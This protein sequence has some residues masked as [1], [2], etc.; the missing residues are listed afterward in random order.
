M[1]SV[2]FPTSVPAEQRFNLSDEDYRF[3]RQYLSQL[4]RET[5]FPAY[6]TTVFYDTYCKFLLFGAD[7]SVRIP[8]HIKMYNKVGDAYGFCLD[9][10][11]IRDQRAGVEFLLSAVIY[12]NKDGII[13]DDKYEYE[14]L[15]FPF[16]K[17]VGELIYEYEKRRNK[18]YKLLAD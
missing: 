11:Y 17:Y 6:D 13:N 15:A 5:D 8:P 4:P 7:K 12:C 14:E 3:V 10:A 1:R 16:M 2:I 9:V 18:K